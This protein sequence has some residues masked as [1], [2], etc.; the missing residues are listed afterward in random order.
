MA[1]PVILF[2]YPFSPYAKKVRLLFAAAGIPYKRCEM[3]IVL[4]RPTLLDLGITYRRIPLLALG[5]DVYCDTAL[6]I[7]II[8]K[9]LGGLAT[10]PADHA[11]EAF[12]D[13]LFS[14]GLACIPSALLSEDFVK[15]RAPIFPICAREDF[16]TL[17]PSGK[18][19]FQANLDIIEKDF[20]A[21]A[22]P[23]I[24]GSKPALADIHLIWVVVWIMSSLG[25]AEAPGS[26][27]DR[28]PKIW[29]M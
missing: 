26:E 11:Y 3:P 7:E 13:Q 10:S 1:A 17:G 29:K 24:G 23:F 14:S 25:V 27:K 8:Q 4:P 16:K 18:A 28:F 9:H 19:E 12:A 2:D 15:D 6:I 5:R 21:D 20:L 22:S